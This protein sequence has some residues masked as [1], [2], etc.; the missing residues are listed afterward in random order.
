M[1]TSYDESSQYV[2]NS[3]PDSLSTEDENMEDSQGRSVTPPPPPSAT[4]ATA[5]VGAAAAADDDKKDSDEDD[6]DDDNDSDVDT[7]RKIRVKKTEIKP[8]G[9][10]KGG[11]NIKGGKGKGIGMGGTGLQTLRRHDN[12]KNL[13]VN[14]GITGKA[15]RRLA[16]RGGVK[17]MSGL[18][19]EE[20]RVCLRRFLTSVIG[21]TIQ[22]TQHAHRKT[23][24][25]QDVLMGLQRQGRTLY[26]FGQN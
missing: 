22:Y 23:V 17:R 2:L 14:G 26:G 12:L 9:M 11:M 8:H 4:I 5:A 21:N 13:V 20:T 19:Y 24:T 15:I 3:V 25:V 6:E 10:G 7:K 1:P 16:R 18:I